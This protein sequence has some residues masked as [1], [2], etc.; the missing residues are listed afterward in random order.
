MSGLI[1]NSKKTGHDYD[2]FDNECGWDVWQKGDQFY[3]GLRIRGNVR[4]RKIFSSE[5]AAVD[6]IRSKT[7]G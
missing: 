3:A 1:E 4:N 5:Q 2:F 7:K 6:Y